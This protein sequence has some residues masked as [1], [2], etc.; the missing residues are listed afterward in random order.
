MFCQKCGKEIDDQAIICPGC[1]VATSNHI[2]QA[3][4]S[5][6]APQII[7]NNTN[8]NTNTAGFSYIQKNKWTAFILCFLLGYL[9]VHRFYVGKSGT[10]LIWLFTGGLMGIGYVVDL[11]LILTGAFRDRAGQPLKG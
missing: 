3:T 11:I 4:Q 6:A 2:P 5:P 1:G 8:T 10:G 9:G 7:I